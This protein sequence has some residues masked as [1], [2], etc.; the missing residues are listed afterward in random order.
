MCFNELQFNVKRNLIKLYQFLLCKLKY[1]GL[2]CSEKCSSLCVF[3]CVS[4]RE[5]R[6]PRVPINQSGLTRLSAH[7]LINPLEISQ[8]LPTESVL[9][10]CFYFILKITK[11]VFGILP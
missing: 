3:K 7:G 5:I 1:Y 11:D 10:S 9:N 8:R 2:I 6:K 4:N